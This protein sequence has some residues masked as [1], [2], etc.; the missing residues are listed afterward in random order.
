VAAGRS[1]AAGR[2]RSRTSRRMFGRSA[3]W[4]WEAVTT[5]GMR[6]MEGCFMNW[7]RIIVWPAVPRARHR[8][9]ASPNG[10]CSSPEG[11]RGLRHGAHR[12]RMGGCGEG[13]ADEGWPAHG[14]VAQRTV[15]WESGIRKLISRSGR[16]ALD[17]LALFHVARPVVHRLTVPSQAVGCAPMASGTLRERSG[18]PLPPEA[19]RT[20]SGFITPLSRFWGAS[21]SS[22]YV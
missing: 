13:A 6:D 10:G 2:D 21:F 5:A 20:R 19:E 22:D 12:G 4:A 14:W 8:C 17:C 16:T 11:D 18:C 7:G 9:A 3:S 1:N 15:S